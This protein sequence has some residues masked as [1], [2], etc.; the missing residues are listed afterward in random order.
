MVD[1]LRREC[2][3]H[4]VLS[5]CEE[6]S[7]LILRTPSGADCMHVIQEAGSGHLGGRDPTFDVRAL[8]QGS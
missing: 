7:P 3:P 1:V 4:Y 8:T 6:A 2:A 5:S